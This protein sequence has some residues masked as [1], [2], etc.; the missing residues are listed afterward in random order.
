MNPAASTTDCGLPGIRSIPY[1]MHMCHFYSDRE[2]LAAT[3]VPYFAAGLRNN[4]RCIWITA[5]PL[6]ATDA[7]EALVRHDPAATAALRAE[8]LIVR[9]HS[10]WYENADGL[11]GK[12]VIELWLAEEE[13]ARKAGYSGLRITGNVTFLTP[14][15]WDLFMEYEEALT[16]ALANR[17]IVALCSYH[18][19]RSSWTDLLDVS[20]RHH[21]TLDRPDQGWQ[22]L[23]G[24]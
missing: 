21:C 12:Q 19:Q 5:E 16:A 23:T 6:S 10:D 15:T 17:R 14:Q 7:K 4:E 24:R 3:L 22:I 2:E 11:Q 20:R 1:G 18:L 8:S 9:D 13:R